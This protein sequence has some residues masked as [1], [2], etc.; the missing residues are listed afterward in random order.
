M[1]FLRPCLLEQF[2]RLRTCRR[3][4]VRVR[5]RSSAM[6]DDSIPPPFP[7]GWSWARNT[8]ILGC[9][10]KHVPDHRRCGRAL[11]RLLLERLCLRLW[12]FFDL[13][14]LVLDLPEHL[15]W[16]IRA[17]KICGKSILL[18]KSNSSELFNDAAAHCMGSLAISA[19]L[20]AILTNLFRS[21]HSD[22]ARMPLIYGARKKW[23]L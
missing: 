12:I 15:T 20:S 11:D 13:S 2:P 5:F 7:Q 8:G 16:T 4:N 3:A 19:I 9:P 22:V 1:K 6:A 10:Y 14:D 23:F 17:A 18:S 21:V